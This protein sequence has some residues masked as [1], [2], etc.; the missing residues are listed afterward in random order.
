MIVLLK[1]QNI[2]QYN[3]KHKRLKFHEHISKISGFNQYGLPTAY[4][5]Q[6]NGY[7]MLY[8]RHIFVLKYLAFTF[9]SCLMCIR[10]FLMVNFVNHNVF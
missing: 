8:L 1:Y 7:K 4:Y 5:N 10:I 2:Y 9:I 6:S 3:P